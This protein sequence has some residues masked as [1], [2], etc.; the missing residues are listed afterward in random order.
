MS[1]AVAVLSAARGLAAATS[2]SA[3]ACCFGR[4]PPAALDCVSWR[5]AGRDCHPATILPSQR[6]PGRSVEMA[7]KHT[8][9]SASDAR[10]RATVSG[11]PSM[12]SPCDRRRPAASWWRGTAIGVVIRAMVRVSAASHSERVQSHRLAPAC[13]MRAGA[14]VNLLP[15]VQA[16]SSLHNL[17]NA[18]DS[19]PAIFTRQRDIEP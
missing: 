1:L 15:P 12:P 11:H 8:I 7:Q 6:V 10:R 9:V 16:S 5:L 19:M 13:P 14:T 3:A 2:L 17:H 4:W 18:A